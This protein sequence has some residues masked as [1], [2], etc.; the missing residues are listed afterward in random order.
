MFA[1]PVLFLTFQFIPYIIVTFQSRLGQGLLTAHGFS[2]L[3]VSTENET[4]VL[5]MDGP[6]L[7]RSYD[8][9]Q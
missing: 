3:Y 8:L 1:V 7:L 9:L 6:D 5:K 4:L 2:C